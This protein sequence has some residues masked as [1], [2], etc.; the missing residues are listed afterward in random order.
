[1]EIRP[2]NTRPEL[3]NQLGSPQGGA[4]VRVDRFTFDELCADTMRL[5]GL[6]KSFQD[7]FGVDP[8]NHWKKCSSCELPIGK[9]EES[10]LLEQGKTTSS[11]CNADF[12][13]Y[14]PYSSVY[15]RIRHDLTLPQTYSTLFL[16]Q[17]REGNAPERT[18]GFMWAFSNGIGVVH[19]DLMHRYIPIKDKDKFDDISDRV[20][21]RLVRL[22]LEDTGKM[23]FVS[24]LGVA[25]GSRRNAKIFAE[26]LF[27]CAE[28][29]VGKG[30]YRYVFRTGRK[31]TVYPII[32]LLGAVEVYSYDED[33]ADDN[34][35]LMSGDSRTIVNTLTQY[36]GEE[37]FK[38]LL[39]NRHGLKNPT[40]PQQ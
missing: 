26:V 37:F 14:H 17:E 33:F 19:N 23:S 24:V 10:H 31:S 32:K 5:N 29:H 36:P 16:A 15:E 7:I 30:Y 2:N 6:I 38:F 11:C 20:L 1:M 39:Q 9:K 40:P 12:V 4:H 35:V 34:L 8:W 28:S 25:E 3:T 13:E 18:I 27:A 21:N 22:D